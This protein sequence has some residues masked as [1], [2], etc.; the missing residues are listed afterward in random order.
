MGDNGDIRVSDWLS[1]CKQLGHKNILLPADEDH[2][3]HDGDSGS[4]CKQQ[5][6]Y[7]TKITVLGFLV[8]YS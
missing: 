2:D 6:N 8:Q 7:L 5:E 1:V 4:E 3:V